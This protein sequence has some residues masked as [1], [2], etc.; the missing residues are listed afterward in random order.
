MKKSLFIV[1]CCIIAVSANAKKKA[2]IEE[3]IQLYQQAVEPYN[4]RD[5][6]AAAPIMEESLNIRAEAAGKENAAY[7]KQLGNLARCRSNMRDFEGAIATDTL[8][9]RVRSEL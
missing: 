9:I 3:S 1:L 5:Y 6:A 2:T 4:A 8:S 7:I